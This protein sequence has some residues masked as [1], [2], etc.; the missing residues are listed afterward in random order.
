MGEYIHRGWTGEVYESNFDSKWGI[1]TIDQILDCRHC[2]NNHQAL[3]IAKEQGFKFFLCP[4]P[5]KYQNHLYK[6]RSNVAR[7]VYVELDYD[8]DRAIK[9]RVA[10]G[11]DISCRVHALVRAIKWRAKEKG[12]DYDL[13]EGQILERFKKGTC[14]KTNLHFDLR[15]VGRGKRSAFTP[16]IDRIDSKRGYTMDNVQVV[17]LFY[18]LMKS[19]FTEV[20]VNKAIKALRRRSNATVLL[21]R[22]PVKP[23][24]IS[25]E[26]MVLVSQY[27]K[28]LQGYLE[29]LHNAKAYQVIGAPVSK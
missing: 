21:D 4:K 7:C 17:C 28:W 10:Y 13:D 27:S 11:K 6:N 12:L 2:C 25:D 22:I 24:Q 26:Y 1:I 29:L 23:I 16:S 8:R 5:S 14:E 9:E 18:N 15:L 3:S 20:E 19:N